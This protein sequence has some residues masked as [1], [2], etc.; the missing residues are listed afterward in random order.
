MVNKNE[1]NRIY[2]ANMSKKSKDRKQQLQN[3]R[4]IFNYK[5]IQEY[6]SNLGCYKCGEK[7]YICLDFH[8]VS[9]NKEIAIGSATCRS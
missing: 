4:R 5:V 9:D 2:Y 8:H 3:N 6:K 1:Y 7:D